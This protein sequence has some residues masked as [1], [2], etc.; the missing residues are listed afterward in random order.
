MQRLSRF[1]ASTLANKHI[2]VVQAYVK[3]VVWTFSYGGGELKHKIAFLVSGELPF[4]ML[5]GIYYLEVAQPQFD[6]DRKVMIHK[7]PNGRTVRL[8]K[9][10]DGSLVENYGCMSASFFYN[11]YKQHREEGMHLVFVSEKREVVK[12]PPK[13]EAVVAQYPD[14]F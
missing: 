4:D 12:S 8:Q 2:M 14:L 11:Y 13:I 6:W 10:K 7:L 1:I 5:L 9:F 3:D